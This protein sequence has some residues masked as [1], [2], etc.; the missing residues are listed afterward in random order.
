MCIN[1]QVFSKGEMQVV[2]RP[3]KIKVEFIITPTIATYF[4][5]FLFSNELKSSFLLLFWPMTFSLSSPVFYFQ[6]SNYFMCGLK[7]E[8]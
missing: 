5:I 1:I 8:S 3:Q 6:F 7:L 2:W 4:F